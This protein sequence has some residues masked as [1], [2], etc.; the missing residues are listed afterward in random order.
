M[1]NLDPITGFPIPEERENSGLDRFA[2]GMALSNPI[3]GWADRR[4]SPSY[5]PDVK[6]KFDIEYDPWADKRIEKYDPMHFVDSMSEAETT[7]IID[8]IERNM[9]TQERAVGIS[10]VAGQ[11]AGVFTNPLITVP[12][13]A[14][15][16]SSIPMMIAAESG[17]EILSELLLHSQQP[18]RTKT[19]SALNIGL[20]AT[21]A[22]VGGMIRDRMAGRSAAREAAE[23]A[24]GGDGM[25][26]APIPSKDEGQI[27]VPSDAISKDAPPVARVESIEGIVMPVRE[28]MPTPNLVD[29]FAPAKEMTAEEAL[30][31][32][33]DSVAKAKVANEAL[34]RASE[35]VAAAKAKIKELGCK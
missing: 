1:P 8:S 21:G 18:L 2:A 15:G 13:V 3:S 24:H 9:E 27:P 20:A 17:G 23:T 14:T 33:N 5:K 12:I 16:G 26:A 28:E 25:Y 32:A 31:K 29:D 35:R 6:Q 4:F 11:V 7:N 30:A 34:A 10:G 22:G 19:E